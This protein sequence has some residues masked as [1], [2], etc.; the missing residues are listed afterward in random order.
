VEYC[1]L[2]SGVNN[3]IATSTITTASC[4]AA[5]INSPHLEPQVPPQI[6]EGGDPGKEGEGEREEGGHGRVG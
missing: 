5:F 4:S 1:A 6:R 3:A 2:N